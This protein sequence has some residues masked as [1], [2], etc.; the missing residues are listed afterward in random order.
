MADFLGSIPQG[1]MNPPKLD[2]Q[3]GITQFLRSG[4]VGRGIERQD[5]ADDE[6]RSLKEAGS[7]ASAVLSQPVE[8][9]NQALAGLEAQFTQ[10]GNKPAAD[11]MLR[12]MQMDGAAQDAA[13]KDV[14]FKASGQIPAGLIQGVTGINA[15]SER[16]TTPIE[17][18]DPETGLP[19]LFQVGSQS[20][21]KRLGIKPISAEDKASA[22]GLKTQ[23]AERAKTNALQRREKVLDA[24][25]QKVQLGQIK[26]LKDQIA[27]NATKAK[28]AAQSA[29]ALDQFELGETL[30][31]ADLSSIYGRGESLYPDLLRN[32]AGIDLMAQRD[33]FVGMLKLAAAGKMK[34]Q[35]S[36]SDSERKTLNDAA[37]TLSNPNISPELAA[38]EIQKA[39]DALRLTLEGQGIAVP[40]TA[41][42]QDQG[43]IS[44]FSDEDLF[45]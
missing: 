16:F 29:E 4:M 37:T 33:K 27:L 14:V 5:A 44:D 15:A 3:T 24:Q 22:V 32:Q 19:A 18:I 10:Q 38:R 17:A 31:N 21:I 39:N 43:S 25:S 45:N 1:I 35:G 28:N 11:A 2:L 13:L 30:I 40:V 26:L 7:S 42:P 36:I 12:F 8:Q 23:A 20:T 6:A 41:Q 9:R 34:G